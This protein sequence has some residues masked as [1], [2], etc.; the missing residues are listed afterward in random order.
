MCFGMINIYSRGFIGNA[1]SDCAIVLSRQLIF[2]FWVQGH[3]HNSTH[4]EWDSV[5]PSHPF[6]QQQLLNQPACCLQFTDGLMAAESARA[7]LLAQLTSPAG[8]TGLAQQCF[9]LAPAPPS[10]EGC[11]KRDGRSS[12]RLD[13]CKN[14]EP[15]L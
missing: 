14:S 11:P 10:G 6:L 1:Q 5:P 15:M 12:S 8:P 7:Y 3:A 4:P 2:L 9:T 13:S